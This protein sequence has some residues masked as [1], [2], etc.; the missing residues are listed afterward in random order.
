MSEL[1]PPLVLLPPLGHDAQLYAP[2]AR[3]LHDTLPVVALDYPGFSAEP[4]ELDFASPGLLE[5]LA[6]HFAARIARLPVAPFALG[7]VSLGGTLTLRIAHLLKAQPPALMLMASGGLPVARVRR[8]AAKAAMAELGAE[9]FARQ[10]L[11]LDVAELESSSL[12]QHVGELS[13]DV[14]AYFRHYY[15]H[16]WHPAHFARRAQLCVA[17]LSSALDV[18][19]RR[20]MSESTSQVQVMWGERDRLFSAKFTERLAASLPHARLHVLAGVGHYPPLEAPERVAAIV[21]AA[22][23]SQE[24]V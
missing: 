21:R 11:G 4:S 22:V 14:R 6:H 15:H 17:M 2:L 7:G 19:F 20:E 9:G 23:R 10:H 13:D 8:D 12:R 18:D 5:R 16:I 24:S 1:R 3:A